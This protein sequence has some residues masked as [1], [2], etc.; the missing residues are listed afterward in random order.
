MTLVQFF[1][2]RSKKKKLTSSHLLGKPFRIADMSHWEVSIKSLNWEHNIFKKLLKGSSHRTAL[3]LIKGSFWPNES[4]LQ[5][6]N[7]SDHKENLI[8]S[9]MVILSDWRSKTMG[10]KNYLMI[11]FQV[12]WTHVNAFWD[13]LVQWYAL[14]FY[15][16]NHIKNRNWRQS[17]RIIE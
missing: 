4:I 1:I 7:R 10:C 9:T 6:C 15:F 17:R 12:I 13:M 2:K 3:W 11:A 8:R 5:C 16:D 14:I